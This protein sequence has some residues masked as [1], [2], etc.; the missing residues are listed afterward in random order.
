ML[1]YFK[2]AKDVGLY[3]VAYPLARH[4]SLI[5]AAAGFIY[6]PIA[7]GLYSGNLTSGFFIH[8]FLGLNTQSLIV[9]GKAKFIMLNNFVVAFLN[10]ILNLRLIPKFGLEGAAFASFVSLS[11]GNILASCELYKISGI[12]PFSKNYLKPVISS[13]L[14]A[15]AYFFVMQKL[16]IN[17]YLQVIFFAA[18]FTIISI[19]SIILTKSLDREDLMIL[20]ATQQKQLIPVANKPILF[21]TIEDVINAG[22]T[23]IGIIVGPNKEQVTGTVK[24]YE[25]LVAGS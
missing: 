2:T 9:P 25:F 20:R 7:T 1:G 22:I 8:T 15:I 11:V 3:R 17:I 24:K 13:C 23:D 21:Y 5:L 19:L 6:F 4:I 16:A 12:H 18:G 10:V 14:L